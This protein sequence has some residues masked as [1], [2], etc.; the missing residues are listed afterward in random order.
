MSVISEAFYDYFVSGGL[1]MLFTPEFQA[2]L[3]PLMP[4]VLIPNA[5]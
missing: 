3:R 1:Q 4:E 5:T 2:V